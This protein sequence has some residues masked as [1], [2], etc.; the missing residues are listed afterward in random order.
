MLFRNHEEQH[1]NAYYMYALVIFLKMFV[2][3]DDVKISLQS[4]TG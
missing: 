2:V 3:Q 4:I 1:Q